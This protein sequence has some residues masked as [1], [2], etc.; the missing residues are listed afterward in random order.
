MFF[1]KIVA[2]IYF[3]CCVWLIVCHNLM[4]WALNIIGSMSGYCTHNAIKWSTLM[5]AGKTAL[6]PSETSLLG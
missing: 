5:I 1:Q 2:S 4:N 6:K 3:L